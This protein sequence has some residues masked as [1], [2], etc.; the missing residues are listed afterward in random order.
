MAFGAVFSCLGLLF[1]LLLGSRYSFIGGLDLQGERAQ[2]DHIVGAKYPTFTSC[3]PG[4]SEYIGI[5]I[6][7]VQESGRRENESC[8]KK[9]YFL[10]KRSVRSSSPFG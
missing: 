2:A 9:G 1:Y 5:G 8:F 7:L 4:L 10:L 3:W 6:P